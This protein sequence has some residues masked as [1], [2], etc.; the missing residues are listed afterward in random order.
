M[1]AANEAQAELSMKWYVDTKTIGVGTTGSLTPKCKAGVPVGGTFQAYAPK[2]NGPL[3]FPADAHVYRSRNYGSGW[4]ASFRNYDSEPIEILTRVMCLVGDADASSTR[5]ST[6]VVVEPQTSECR[7]VECPSGTIATSGGF[8]TGTSG[9]GVIPYLV[10]PHAERSWKV[11]FRNV[12]TRFART[13]HAYA[14]CLSNVD[15]WFDDVDES[16]QTDPNAWNMVD[17]YTADEDDMISG[18]GYY[19]PW[20]TRPVYTWLRE[21]PAGEVASA[22]GFDSSD[23]GYF[24]YVKA[25][26]LR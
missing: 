2:P 11:C 14:Q 7:I 13:A 22:Q 18:V 26:Y 21:T 23:Y 10:R 12:Y 4:Y 5:V 19:A 15:V 17:W 3:F 6:Q 1:A 16:I 25:R 9:R 24:L 8:E 20:S